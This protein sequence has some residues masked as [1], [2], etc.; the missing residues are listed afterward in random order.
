VSYLGAAAFD[1]EWQ[2]LEPSELLQLGGDLLNAKVDRPLVIRGAS[3]FRC[4]RT[5]QR[6]AGLDVRG[7]G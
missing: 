7:S 1:W 4:G 5:Q 2:E 3:E 6:N